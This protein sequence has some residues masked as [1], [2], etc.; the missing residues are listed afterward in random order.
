MV[1]KEVTH[2]SG[3]PARINHT[4]ISLEV[5]AGVIVTRVLKAAKPGPRGVLKLRWKGLAVCGHQRY[6]QPRSLSRRTATPQQPVDG[7]DPRGHRL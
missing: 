6:S 5:E 1:G 3:K 4:R 7:W 2:D